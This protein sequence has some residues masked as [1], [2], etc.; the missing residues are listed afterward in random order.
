[1]PNNYA[2]NAEEEMA[3]IKAEAENFRRMRDD[4]KV[5]ITQEQFTKGGD[6]LRTSFTKPA[7]TF[8]ARPL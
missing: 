7:Y 8:G 3:K 5:T 6:Y 1:M 4:N 2:I